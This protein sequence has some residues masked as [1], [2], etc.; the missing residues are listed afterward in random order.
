LITTPLI[1]KKNNEV[2]PL[3]TSRLCPIRHRGLTRRLSQRVSFFYV[4]QSVTSTLL[5]TQT[6]NSY[7]TGSIGAVTEMPFFTT[8]IGE[9]SPFLRGFT[10]SLI[11]LTGAF[12]SFFAG[13]LADRFGGLV[14]VAVGALVFT[15]GA[16]LEGAANTLV[17][18]LVGRALCGIGEG[19]WLSN[20]S[21]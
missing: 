6:I 10:V 18:F 19:L 11:M 8:S 1:H 4:S 9:L 17:T 14:I 21:V 15:I 5:K 7:D 2:D 20:V 13:Q 12:P 16:V 3:S